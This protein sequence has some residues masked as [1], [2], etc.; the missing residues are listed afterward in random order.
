MQLWSFPQ[1]M[2]LSQYTRTSSSDVS[3]PDLIN[4]KSCTTERERIRSLSSLLISVYTLNVSELVLSETHITRVRGHSQRERER[5]DLQHSHKCGDARTSGGGKKRRKYVRGLIDSVK[6][7][8]RGVARA[9]DGLQQ[10]LAQGEHK[11]EIAPPLRE[12]RTS[13]KRKRRRKKRKKRRKKG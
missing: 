5:K 10:G 2:A 7:R 1:R 9:F 8:D 4:S 6:S 11:R 3:S 13:K 12:K